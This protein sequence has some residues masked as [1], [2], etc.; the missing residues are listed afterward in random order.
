[1]N[2]RQELLDFFSEYPK[3]NGFRNNKSFEEIYYWLGEPWQVYE[4]VTICKN[5][6][7]AIEAVAN[8]LEFKFGDRTDLNIK[9]DFVKQMV[10]TAIR[11]ILGYFGYEP[12]IQKTFLKGSAQ[13]FRSGMHYQFN[14]KSPRTK[15]LQ[16]EPKIIH[17]N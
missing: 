3:Y 6:R 1:M 2:K 7:P 13:W 14:E 5:K 4:M 15:E 11:H 12:T 8:N 9:E 17:K 16:W 10:G